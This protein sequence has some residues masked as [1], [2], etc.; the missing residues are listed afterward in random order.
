MAKAIART[1][2]VLSARVPNEIIREIDR[3]CKKRGITRSQ[4][5]TATLAKDKSGEIM[6]MSKGGKLELQ[7]YTIPVD[8]QNLLAGLGLLTAGITLFSLSKQALT[9]AKDDSGRP[10]FTDAQ[11]DM[12]AGVILV[13]LAFVGTGAFNSILNEA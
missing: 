11:V 13:T 7:G 9:N 5:V 10:K 4:W 6:Q 1:S 2:S 3:L 12:I 8:L